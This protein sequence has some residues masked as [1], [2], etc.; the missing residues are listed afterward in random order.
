[1]KQSKKTEI[2]RSQ[3]I[4]AA[5]S[6]FSEKGFPYASLR[7]ICEKG[8]FS[9]GKLFH[10]FEDKNDLYLACIEHA[11]T[12]LTDHILRFDFDAAQNLEEN[13]VNLFIH[14]QSFW[15][16]HPD[17]ISVLFESRVAAPPEL[18]KK[19]VPIGQKTFL[20]AVKLK[21]RN[22]FSFYYPNSPQKQSFLVGVWITAHDYATVGIGYQKS[23]VYNEGELDSYLQKQNAMFEKV[24]IAFLYGMESEQFKKIFPY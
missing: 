6:E 11:Y 17:L 13:S 24:L 8:N 10:H 22:M 21:L 19:I 5:L 9:N 7:R 18:R 1:M 2:S 14:W 3:I 12:L 4:E 23:L 16:M 20:A 15:H